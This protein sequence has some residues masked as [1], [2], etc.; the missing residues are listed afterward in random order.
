[1]VGARAGKLLKHWCQGLRL[2]LDTREMTEK[3]PGA[4]TLVPFGP[5]FIR[6]SPR[7]VLACSVQSPVGPRLRLF[8][9]HSY[10]HCSTSSKIFET[11][12]LKQ[13]SRFGSTRKSQ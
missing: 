6:S 9:L 1:M 8:A 11:C 4:K 13:L 5:M 7:T 2:R 12:T 10:T 3:S